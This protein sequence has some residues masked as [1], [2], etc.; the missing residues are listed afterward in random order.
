MQLANCHR[1][2]CGGQVLLTHSALLSIKGIPTGKGIHCMSVFSIV[3]AKAT[4]V[5][6]ALLLM[7]SFI[8]S[9][10]AINYNSYYTCIYD[11]Y[12]YTIVLY[13]S[14]THVPSLSSG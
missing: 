2:R 9:V 8:I 5:H 1:Y 11:T 4:T 7:C 6:G 12:V 3:F 13:N 10:C 14:H